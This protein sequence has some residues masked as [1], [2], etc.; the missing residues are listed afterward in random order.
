MSKPMALPVLISTFGFIFMSLGYIINALVLRTPADWIGCCVMVLI[1]FLW[2]FSLALIEIE[3]RHFQFWLIDWFS[4]AQDCR[5][6]SSHHAQ[7]LLMISQI[8]QNT[9]HHPL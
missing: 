2:A 1:G 5:V 4:D 6:K 9:A 7:S 3:H 8:I